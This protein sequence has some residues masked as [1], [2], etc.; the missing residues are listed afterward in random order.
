MNCA[1]RQ[2]SPASSPS[3][4]KQAIEK[5]E[6][7]LHWDEETETEVEQLGLSGTEETLE[8]PPEDV[9]G[10]GTKASEARTGLLEEGPLLPEQS[11]SGSW[12]EE[13]REEKRK[14]E[15]PST[16]TTTRL[17]SKPEHLGTESNTSGAG[18]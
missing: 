15:D 10:K 18:S 16:E 5:D 7:F 2:E 3:F 11:C 6:D 9:E 8:S 12:G 13:R 1:A 4:L 17:S 14:D